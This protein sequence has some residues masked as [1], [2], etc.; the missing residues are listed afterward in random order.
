ML[1]FLRRI[2]H[3]ADPE[4]LTYLWQRD[5]TSKIAKKTTSLQVKYIQKVPQMLTT[6]NKR[7][8]GVSFSMGLIAKPTLKH[9]SNKEI[10]A[11]P[12]LWCDID[13]KDPN[14]ADENLFPSE[15]SILDML[16]NE[17][18]P[19]GLYPN[20][21][22]NSG[23]GLHLYWIFDRLLP[24]TEFKDRVLAKNLLESIQR[25]IREKS[26]GFGIDKTDDISRMLRLPGTLNFKGNPENPP[27]C[28]VIYDDDST[29]SIETLDK[30]I[31]DYAKKNWLMSSS[32]VPSALSQQNLDA[33]ER[34]RQNQSIRVESTGTNISIEAIGD[35][36]LM[37]DNC[38][39]IRHVVENF[40]VTAEPMIKDA[41]SNLLIA[42]NGTDFAIELCKNRFG[43]EFDAEKTKKRLDHYVVDSKPTSC[44]KIRTSCNFCDVEN[45]IVNRLGKKCPAAIVQSKNVANAIENDDKTLEDVLTNIPEEL[46]ELKVPIG[47]SISE[48]GIFDFQ[49][50]KFAV[51]SPVFISKYMKEVDNFATDGQ[52]TYDIG[53]TWYEIS[54]LIHNRRWIKTLVTPDVVQDSS[55]V[56]KYLAQLGILIDSTQGKIAAPYFKNFMKT[57]SEEIPR[58]DRYTSL[59]WHDDLF[60]IPTMN[61]EQNFSVNAGT[62]T[63]EIYRQ[64]SRDKL[65]ELIR[66]CWKYPA[67]RLFID[68]SLAAPLLKKMH[69]RN[70][71]INIFGRTQTGKTASMSIANAIWGSPKLMF[72]CNS[73]LN[74]IE[75]AAAER[76][77]LPTF[78]NEWQAVP[79]AI[80]QA[81]A[82]D[83]VHRFELGQIK[84]RLDRNSNMRPIKNFRGIL[85]IS[86]EEPIM[87]DNAIGGSF[88]RILEVA[89]P[90]AIGELDHD[91]GIFEVNTELCL[92]IYDVTANNFGFIGP[93]FLEKVAAEDPELLHK[94]FIEYA[95][96]LL[97]A[98]IDEVSS[99]HTQYLSAL[100]NADYRFQK[101]ILEIDETEAKETTSVFISQYLNELE[102]KSEISDTK[103]ALDFI[104]DW[105]R[106]NYANFYDYASPEHFPKLYFGFR[107]GD[108]LCI[109]PEVLKDWLTRA[110]FS[111]GKILQELAQEGK[112]KRDSKQLTVR[113]YDPFYRTRKRFI[114]FKIDDEETDDDTELESATNP[115]ST[116]KQ[117]NEQFDFESAMDFERQKIAAENKK[118]ERDY[119]E[120][121]GRRINFDK[122]DTISN[123][124][125]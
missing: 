53:K 49:A 94:E 83:I 75:T 34:M 68:A 5:E 124:F 121:T 119:Y 36:Q 33:V 4:Q 32:N 66:K 118:L 71:S 87:R 63:K 97:G 2:F 111:Y 123:P 55:T 6:L 60:V 109:I 108:E 54:A 59:G 101:Y 46:K 42:K 69:C 91:T 9:V 95:K 65:I 40:N 57:N 77:D 72:H 23:H 117:T 81:G 38:S 29:F 105:Q 8:H 16:E 78:A 113:R 99:A 92:E 11:I 89:M 27:M 52:N 24:T 103:R 44:S 30:I 1:K 86:A 62:S 79:L 93:E 70:F 56:H 10:I 50:G 120:K 90:G 122:I 106:V 15:K 76:N 115:V 35:V 96:L 67:V 98:R 116:T 12:C 125:E 13:I 88:S 104:F 84:F 47:Y 107:N 64:G 37:I 26:A 61:H 51:D 100:A 14:H 18:R 41:L 22:V 19:L 20:I 28:R 114:V 25:I 3:A 74:A 31:D 80:R 112:I 110:G 39:F 73:T 17:M 48:R 21:I 7:P 82:N 43:S 58:I 102:S 45:C 85:C